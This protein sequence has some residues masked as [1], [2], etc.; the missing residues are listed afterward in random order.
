MR[1]RERERGG[2]GHT[3]FQQTRIR[4][5]DR[6]KRAIIADDAEQERRRIASRCEIKR[7]QINGLLFRFI[8]RHVRKRTLDADTVRDKLFQTVRA[9]LL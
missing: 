7:D 5:L 2:T 8:S 4:R 3:Q 6:A 9:S 1:E